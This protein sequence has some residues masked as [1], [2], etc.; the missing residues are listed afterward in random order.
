VAIV[1]T[2]D[3]FTP[4]VNDPYSFGQIAAANALSDIY[5][6]GATPKTALNMV[7]FSPKKFGLEV[8]NRGQA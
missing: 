5:A 6:M 1:Q 7:C 2:I 8:L 3:F 4:I